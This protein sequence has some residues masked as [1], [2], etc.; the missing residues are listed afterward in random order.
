MSNDIVSTILSGVLG[1]IAA[2]VPGLA[3]TRHERRLRKAAQEDKQK[4]EKAIAAGGRVLAVEAAFEV[5]E[6]EVTYE[7]GDSGEGVHCKQWHRIKPR[8][9]FTTL[10][11][12]F[13]I[14]VACP[15]ASLREPRVRKLDEGHP[16]D[17]AIDEADLIRTGVSSQGR[18]LVSGRYGPETEPISI[19]L[20]Q[21]F[22]KVFCLTEEEVRDAY[23]GD[24]W[25]QEFGAAAVAS[26]MRELSLRV[27]Y[28][29]SHHGRMVSLPSLVVFYNR[30]ETIH[31]EETDRI[32][33]AGALT[34][35]GKTATLRVGNPLIGLSYAISWMPPPQEA[36]PEELPGG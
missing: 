36:A 16:L 4:A 29:P 22:D 21:P 14:V 32:R 1:I 13:D 8:H 7:Y 30:T 34:F 6:Y 28:P 18:I 12:P 5:D 24:E 19:I 27:T 35:D 17:V 26:P 9:T 25:R 2:G 10:A 3:V 31:A 33:A 23:S 20:E 15:G 11:I